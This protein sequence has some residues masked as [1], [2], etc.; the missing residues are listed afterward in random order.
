MSIHY[1]FQDVL[2]LTLYG[3]V[4]A[5]AFVS[6]CY[7]LLRRNNAFASDIKSPLRLRR[8]MAAFFAAIG[9]SHLWWL[10]FYFTNPDRDFYNTRLICIWFDV[11]I[12]LPTIMGT[13]LAMLQDRR[14]SLQPIV[15][16]MLLSLVNLLIISVYGYRR[17]AAEIIIFFVLLLYIFIVMERAVR[18]YG[19]WLRDNYADL[20]H[21]VVWQNFIVLAV[22]LLTTIIYG[23]SDGDK[24]NEMLIEVADII[25]I[26]VL[27]WRVETLQTL[28]KHAAE[29]V[30]EPSAEN[31]QEPIETSATD[32]PQIELLLQKH[33][34]D[35]QYYLH[36]DVSL[37]HLAQLIGINKIHLSQYFAQ[38][39]LTYNT[40]INGLR[41]EHFIR[42][43]QRSTQTDR[44]DT[45]VKLAYKSGYKSYST[46]CSVFK[47]I[48]GQTVTSW[49]QE[50]KEK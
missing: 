34:V 38:Q 13:M 45:V 21:K 17:S 15:V 32:F 8:W 48:K 37:S 26:I 44:D 50:Q 23:F 16:A 29:R 43:Y 1:S 6:C 47:L 49:M 14:R 11:L 19:R 24:A 36:H 33:C 9:A 3:S 40:Y 42:L 46:F 25:L 10:L 28:E 30:A 35:G 39:G 4:T 18:E 22:F 27:L 12:T 2:F 20:E 41:I 5:I 7:L 31:I